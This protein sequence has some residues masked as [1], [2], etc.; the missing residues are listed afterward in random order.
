M[1]LACAAVNTVHTVPM[2][3]EAVTVRLLLRSCGNLQA[4]ILLTERG[5]VTEGRTLVRSLLENAFCVGALVDKP[6]EFLALLVDD[7]NASRR[8]QGKFIIEQGFGA[9]GEAM[10]ELQAAIDAIHKGQLLSPKTV[11]KL[12]P[13]TK[14]Y[15]A[16]QRLSDGSAHASAQSLERH[17]LRNADRSGWTYRW[18]AGDDDEIAATLSTAVQ[19]ALAVGIGVAQTLRGA[20]HDLPEG[21]AFTGLAARLQSMPQSPEL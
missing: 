11:A 15:L 10:D 20:S 13:L 9:L 14:L 21:A 8:Q 1:S 3:A 2:T 19:A 6:E 7:H 4:I 5:M 16:Y 12:S 18:G 17:V